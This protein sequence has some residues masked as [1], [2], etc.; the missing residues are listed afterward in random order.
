MTT[1]DV[2]FT[3][4]DI[5]YIEQAYETL[6]ELCAS[7]NL[8]PALMEEQIAAGRLPQP[9]YTLPGGRR[10]FPRDYF[11]LLEAAGS[12]ECMR[13]HFEKRFCEAAERA[14]LDFN[15]EWNPETEWEDYLDGTYWVC[16]WQATPEAMIEKE[17]LIRT[18]RTLDAGPDAGSASWRA[19][20]AQAVDALDTLE[21]P[22]TDYDRARWD[23][24][25]RALYVTAL[26][27]RYSEVFD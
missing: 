15:P 4:E 14:G 18:I 19:Q 2:Q 10:M 16:L 9:A 5:A 21:R 17:R 25:S 13:E 24:T 26:R 1:H 12:A 27:E 23:Y 6:G 20:L 11:E 8:E 7:R 3:T 22:F